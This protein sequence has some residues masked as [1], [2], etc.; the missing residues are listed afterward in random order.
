[1]EIVEVNKKQTVSGNKRKNEIRKNIMG[2][3]LVIAPVIG[4]CAF[5]L[6]PMA[7]S[8][9]ISF[10]ELHSYNGNNRY[11]VRNVTGNVRIEVSHR[12]IN[13][14]DETEEQ[15]NEKTEIKDPKTTVIVCVAVGAGVVVVGAGVAVVFIIKK[16]KIKKG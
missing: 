14:A 6:F 4:F 7:V 16:R 1:M 8:F 11:V 12:A 10:T 15:T 13:S 3:L 2:T 5:T 9:L